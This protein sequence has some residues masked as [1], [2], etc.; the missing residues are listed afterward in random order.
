MNSPAR[1][2]QEIQLRAHELWQERG[3][4]SGTPETDWFKAEQELSRKPEGALSRVAREV[5]TAIGTVVA[6]VT[7]RRA[8]LGL[9]QE[10]SHPLP[11]RDPGRPL[12]RGVLRPLRHVS[13]ADL[14]LHGIAIDGRGEF[15]HGTCRGWT[16][17]ILAELRD[18]DGDGLIE[19]FG[20]HI[21]AM[22]NAVGVGKRGPAAGTS[23][24]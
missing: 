13:E 17:V 16:D 14:V 6:L 3:R 5:G 4:P 9:P 21:D 24:R 15:G 23:H 1:S 11:L 19:T 2:H 20:L 18:G 7:E 10:C 12:L 8:D 22:E